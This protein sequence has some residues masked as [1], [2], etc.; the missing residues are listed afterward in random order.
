MNIPTVKLSESDS[1]LFASLLDQWRD[2]KRLDVSQVISTF[3]PAQTLAFS[4]YMAA[5][6]GVQ[7]LHDL[8]QLSYD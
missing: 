5:F 7:A 6:G 1:T 4:S 8:A 3:T 2:N